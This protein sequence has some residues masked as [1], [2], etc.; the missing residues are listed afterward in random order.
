MTSKFPGT[1]QTKP[2]VTVLEFALIA[3]IVAVFMVA[4]LDLLPIIGAAT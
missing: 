3:G 1:T 4:V 2:A